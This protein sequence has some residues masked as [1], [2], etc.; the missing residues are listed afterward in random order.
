MPFAPT[1]KTCKY[2]LFVERVLYRSTL[3]R[4]VRAWPPGTRLDGFHPTD[5]AVITNLCFSSSGIDDWIQQRV[6]QDASFWEPLGLAPSGMYFGSTQGTYFIYPG[7][8]SQRCSSYDPR[9]R[10]WYVAGSSGSKNVIM[11]LDQSGSMVEPRMTL[12]K[13][14]A[15]RVVDTLTFGDRIAIVSF[16]AKATK[17]AD[18]G[19]LFIA[20]DENK[21]QLNQVIDSLIPTGNTDF[22]AAFNAA[23]QILED[24]IER[25]AHIPCNTAILF[26]TDGVL[27]PDDPQVTSNLVMESVLD[28]INSTSA[29][30]K[31]PIQ[32]F[33]YSVSIDDD[34]HE[35]PRQLACAVD[36]GIWSR[37]RRPQDIVDALSSYYLLFASGLGSESNK[38]F[39]AWVEA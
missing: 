34:V 33:T 10:P 37:V 31:H 1:A 7:R 4:A 39:A 29:K 24:S 6:A 8:H 20:S 5:L 22:H 16:N 23:F 36:H 17:I 27:E 3:P 19:S 14:A 21:R 2:R 18:N 30:L 13:E 15:K 26:L 9:I 11:V 28:R 25:E 35:F 32:L 38:N 12:L